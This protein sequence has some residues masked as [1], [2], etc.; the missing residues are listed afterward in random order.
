VPAQRQLSGAVAAFRA[1]SKV[2]NTD[3]LTVAVT[4][5]ENCFTP[6]PFLS[7]NC[8]IAKKLPE[9]PPGNVAVQHGNGQSRTNAAGIFV[10]VIG[11]QV[12]EKK[13]PTE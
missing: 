1:A 13:T 12:A 5:E 8:V 2:G 10:H 4:E 3:E 11:H 7:A 6:R 9:T